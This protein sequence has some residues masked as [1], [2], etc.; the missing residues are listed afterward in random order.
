MLTFCTHGVLLRTIYAEPNLLNATTH[1]IV[2]EIDE[3][4]LFTRK[5][6]AEGREMPVKANRDVSS[7]TCNLLLGTLHR[8]LSQYP[9]L[10]LILIVNLKSTSSIIFPPWYPTGVSMGLRVCVRA[11][12]SIR[13]SPLGLSVIT[14]YKMVQQAFQCTYGEQKGVGGECLLLSRL[15]SAAKGTAA[16]RRPWRSDHEAQGRR[17]TLAK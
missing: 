11:C 12:L 1:I 3:E 9:H 7:H 8:I 6:N 5:L 2:D 15:H 4:D 14:W 10:K 13:Y 17:M 16:S